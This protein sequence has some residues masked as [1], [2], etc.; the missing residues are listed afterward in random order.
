MNKIFSLKSKSNKIE[1]NEESSKDSSI[2]SKNKNIDLYA[3]NHNKLTFQKTSILCVKTKN[4]KYYSEKLKTLTEL[5]IVI[6]RVRGIP[7]KNIDEKML[8]EYH[9]Y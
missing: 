5:T 3:Y 6:L 7:Q 2:S 9:Q 8:K 1:S 4:K